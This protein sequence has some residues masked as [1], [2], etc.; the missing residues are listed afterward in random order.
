MLMGTIGEPPL[1]EALAC[2][3]TARPG[4]A[5]AGAAEP[6]AAVCGKPLAELNIDGAVTVGSDPQP[7]IASS[8]KKRA[9]VRSVVIFKPFETRT[10]ATK[11]A[12]SLFHVNQASD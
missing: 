8:P 10:T 7:D 2:G 9:P 4:A 6:A 1:A 5:E 12:R 11:V 3:P